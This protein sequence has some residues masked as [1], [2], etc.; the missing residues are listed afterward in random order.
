MNTIHHLPMLNGLSA[1]QIFLPP[2]W[3]LAN[4]HDCHALTIYEYLCTKF[5]H[6]TQAQLKKRFDNRL[7]FAQTHDGF[8][9]LSID[10]KY[11]HY[12]NQHIHYYRMV[13]HEVIV[14]FAHKIINENERFIVVDKPHFLTISPSGNYV[15]QT[16]LTRLK[17]QFNNPD[18]TP[19]HRLDKETAGL[20]LFCK[21]KAYRATYQ[22]LFAN[23][24]IK[25]TYHAI[26]KYDQTLHFPLSLSLHMTRGN[27]F[28]TMVVTN[29]KPNSHTHINLLMHNQHYGKYQLM[30]TTGKLHQLRVHLN[31]LGIPI[32]ND[33]LYPTICHKKM[34]DFSHP[35]QLLAKSLEFTDPISNEHYYFNS[36]Q[37]LFL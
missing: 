35:L 25:K 19:I 34:D 27:P 30:P 16:L 13:D 22:T 32:Q 14:P 12:H 15:Q 3:Q 29:Q 7:V 23:H 1:S 11:I 28:Y 21:K 4:L 26:A 8:V 17:E 20:I 6:I 9:A 24:Q 10:D 31:H 36:T 18:I 33:P 2:I 37:D 5:H